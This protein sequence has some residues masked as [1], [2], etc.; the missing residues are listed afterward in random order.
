MTN[1]E[2]LN[3]HYMKKYFLG[4]K[5][6][7]RSLELIAIILDD[8]FW[9]ELF[10]KE[11]SAKNAKCTTCATATNAYDDRDNASEA[12]TNANEPKV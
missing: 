3:Q 12:N 4:T 6:I 1:E 5:N 8:F 10:A 11:F 9:D 2:K 7:V